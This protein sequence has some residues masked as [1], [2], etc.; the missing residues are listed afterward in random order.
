MGIELSRGKQFMNKMTLLRM[1]YNVCAI[2]Y[3]CGDLQCAMN[4][5]IGKSIGMYK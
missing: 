2:L 4:M 3:M 1:V 5:V